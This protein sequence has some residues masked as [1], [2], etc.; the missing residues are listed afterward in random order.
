MSRARTIAISIKIQIPRCYLP[1]MENLL[2]IS[3]P[4]SFIGFWRRSKYM[5]G[6]NQI[7]RW[8]VKFIFEWSV[9]C[10]D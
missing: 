10:Y 9:T 7:D 3:T 1:D 5:E 8:L 2:T 4:I 6:A